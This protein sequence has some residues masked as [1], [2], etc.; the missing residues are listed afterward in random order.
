MTLR[1][2]NINSNVL[3]FCREQIGLDLETVKAIIPKIELIEVGSHFPTLNQLDTLAKL[4]NVPRWVF[5]SE[6]IPE[7]YQ[8]DKTVPAFRQFKKN[9]ADIFNEPKV[10]GLVAKVERLRELIIDFKSDEGEK[11]VE[12]DGPVISEKTPPEI[13]AKA[14]R[15]WLGTS[16]NLEFKNWRKLLEEKGIF[17]FLTSKYIEWSHIE[18]EILR[19]LA[20]YHPILPIIIINDS[21]SKKAQSFTLFHE[22]CHL[23]KKENAINNWEY[24]YNNIEKWCDDVSGNFLMPCDEMKRSFSELSDTKE[25]WKLAQKFHV[26]SYAYLVRCKRLDLIDQKTYEHFENLLT[27][28]YKEI[29]RK[30]KE[31]N[32]KIARNRSSEILKQYGAIYTTTVFQAYYNQEIGLN[33]L[34]KLLNVKNPSH[35]FEM[36]RRL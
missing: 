14:I 33:K 28:E 7:E 29:Q 13:A 31:S 25:L 5:I 32:V 16:K 8:F 34:T 12:F 1:I 24:F 23:L 36:E 17:I 15:N 9:N 30:L 18:R 22:L 19:G 26:S 4:Y 10:R 3:R 2:D 21:D 35:V 6:T 11:F 20:V 27:N